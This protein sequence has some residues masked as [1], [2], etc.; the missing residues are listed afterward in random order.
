MGSPCATPDC[1]IL[2]VARLICPELVAFSVAL[3]PDT[4]DAIALGVGNAHTNERALLF[5]MA[6]RRFERFP[7]AD[8]AG[9]L[10]TLVIGLDGRVHVVFADVRKFQ[11]WYHAVRGGQVTEIARVDRSTIRVG[12]A[13]RVGAEIV[14]ITGIASDLHLARFD[15]SAWTVAPLGVGVSADA[16][17]IAAADGSVWVSHPVSRPYRDPDLHVV[18]PDG[19]VEEVPHGG[20]GFLVP[21]DGA[22]LAAVWPSPACFQ[23]RGSVVRCIGRPFFVDRDCEEGPCSECA[24]MGEGVTPAVAAFRLDDDLLLAKIEV[25]VDRTFG[26]EEECN[27]LACGCRRPVVRDES[28]AELVFFRVDLTTLEWS[29][30]ARYRVD[31]DEHIEMIGRQEGDRA[32]I[33]LKTPNSESGRTTTIDLL[34]LDLAVWRGR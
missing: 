3:A 33:A 5:R 9:E 26:A 17:V 21:A 7:E 25:S 10:P 11:V 18:G 27:D 13:T 6:E 16:K 32:V 2:D 15:G 30:Q 12:S 24:Q 28:L 1:P 4:G 23:G 8:D 14:A 34:T 31:V 22:W 29:E 19:V 20:H